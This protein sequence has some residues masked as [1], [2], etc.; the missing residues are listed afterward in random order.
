MS[1]MTKYIPMNDV[2][3]HNMDMEI[4]TIKNDTA[5]WINKIIHSACSTSNLTYKNKV[6]KKKRSIRHVH[7]D[8]MYPNERR[9]VS[10]HGHGD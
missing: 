9:T 1:I 8:E 7:H 4:E 6:C 5:S 3:C 10:Q 2:P